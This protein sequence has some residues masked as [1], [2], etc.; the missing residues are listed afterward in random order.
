MS[1]HE[2]LSAEAKQVER[3][4][5]DGVYINGAHFPSILKRLFDSTLNLPQ[6]C[7]WTARAGMSRAACSRTRSRTPRIRPRTRRS[8]RAA[9]SRRRQRPTRSSRRCRSCISFRPRRRSL[10]SQQREGLLPLQLAAPKHTLALSTR[11]QC[12]RVSCPRRATRRTSCSP[13][14]CRRRKSLTTGCCAA[15]LC[16]VKRTIDRGIF[17]IVRLNV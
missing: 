11:R 1:T 10:G 4:P 7:T 2:F 8:S 15:P 3:P 16:S 13:A 6:V 9:R 5:D 17:A 14:N 12:A